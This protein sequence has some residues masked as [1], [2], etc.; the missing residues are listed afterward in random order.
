[1][2][3]SVTSAVPLMKVS[4]ES[5]SA[6]FCAVWVQFTCP[7]YESRLMVKRKGFVLSPMFPA[8]C[9]VRESCL[10]DLMLVILPPE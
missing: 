1:M 9:L 7:L 2:C 3:F 8:T 6:P 4:I 5:L 10:T